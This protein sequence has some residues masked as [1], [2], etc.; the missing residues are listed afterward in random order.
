M[1]GPIQS[2]ISGGVN[3]TFAGA[4]AGKHLKEQQEQI[5]EQQE[6]KK[7]QQMQKEDALRET[8]LGEH[9]D[10]VNKVNEES[11]KEAEAEVNAALNAVPGKDTRLGKN[12]EGLEIT[13][14]EAVEC[15]AQ[16]IAVD[17][18][19][20]YYS[21]PARQTQ[22]AYAAGRISYEDALKARR[23]LFRQYANIDGRIFAGIGRDD[24]DS[25]N[26]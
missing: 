19:R 21:N 26:D 23:T 22:L 11:M 15:R 9:E 6:Q 24:N 16:D 13:Y 20:V 4:V 25:K 17:R 5:K 1:P 8:I 18:L 3:A 2:A 7:E 14:D 12:L 10:L